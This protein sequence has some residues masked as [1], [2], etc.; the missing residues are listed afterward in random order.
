VT[1]FIHPLEAS[2]IFLWYAEDFHLFFIFLFFLIAHFLPV[3]NTYKTPYSLKAVKVLD[4]LKDNPVT[5]KKP[6]KT[7]AVSPRKVLGDPVQNPY[8]NP[9]SVSKEATY[10]TKRF[11]ERTSDKAPTEAM[12]FG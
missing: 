3:K 5:A 6:T 8:H 7:A 9:A 1:C 11:T 12:Q 2:F 10:S 4:D